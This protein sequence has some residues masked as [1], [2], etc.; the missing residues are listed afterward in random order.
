MHTFDKDGSESFGY[1]TFLKAIIRISPVLCLGFAILGV[2]ASLVSPT[3]PGLI[4]GIL[5]VTM[6]MAAASWGIA[7]ARRLKDRVHVDDRE[8]TKEG[9]D[10]GRA[11]LPWDRVAKVV[12]R[13]G[14]QRLE[15]HAADGTAVLKLEYALDRFERLSSIVLERTAPGAF[16]EAKS[17]PATFRP[18]MPLRVADAVGFPLVVAIAVALVIGRIWIG[19]PSL[20]F[21]LYVGL[22]GQ[23][24]AVRV[25]RAAI[26]FL[27][28]LRRRAIRLDELDE[29]VTP[30]RIGRGSHGS[31]TVVL[32]LRGGAFRTIEG[33]HPGALA[34]FRT[35]NAARAS[36]DLPPRGEHEG[37]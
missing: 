26:T 23:W 16:G 1:P 4:V 7:I 29:D 9:V 6:F 8:I 28:P 2:H 37:G 30:V 19:W 24:Y 25:D 32:R 20:V 33:V 18:P 3:V 35:I 14:L 17:F 10:G 21:L 11:T 22:F 34:L 13:P 36:V 15:L 12:E 27:Y 31:L 5:A